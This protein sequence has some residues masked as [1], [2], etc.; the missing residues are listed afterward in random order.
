VQA[1]S[2]EYDKESDE[3]VIGFDFKPYDKVIHSLDHIS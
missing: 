2:F 3:Y 1:A